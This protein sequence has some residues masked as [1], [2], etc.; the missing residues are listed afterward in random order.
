MKYRQFPDKISNNQLYYLKFNK[1]YDIILQPQTVSLNGITLPPIVKHE[2]LI[3][4]QKPGD[5]ISSIFFIQVFTLTFW[6][7]ILLVVIFGVL[8]IIIKVKLLRQSFD[9]L[10]DEILQIFLITPN[11]T[12]NLN[13]GIYLMQIVISL[14]MFC[15]ATSFSAFLISK[16]TVNQPKLP[17]NSLEDLMNQTQYSICANPFSSEYFDL[18]EVTGNLKIFNGK[19]CLIE[20]QN[21]T[22]VR[23]VDLINAICSNKNAAYLSSPVYFKLQL[24]SME[25]R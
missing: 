10:I 21:D 9:N 8:I 7:A 5:D 25:K 15:I 22:F 24:I 1:V 13:C 3:Y 2:N 4:F 11:T 19:N 16:L 14:F 23:R 18:Q 12:E 20:Y 17:F 6:I